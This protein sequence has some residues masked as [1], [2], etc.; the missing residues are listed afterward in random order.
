M[1]Q[2][3]RGGAKRR[4]ESIVNENSKPWPPPPRFELI[5]PPLMELILHRFERKVVKAVD[6]PSSVSWYDWG[7]VSATLYVQ[8]VAANS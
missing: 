4:R 2:C 5:P 3:E 1:N 6:A 8:V 7:L